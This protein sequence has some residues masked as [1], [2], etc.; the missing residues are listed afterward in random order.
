[1]YRP[2]RTARSRRLLELARSPSCTLANLRD[3]AAELA[4]RKNKLAFQAYL[5]VGRL[6]ES[7]EKEE[8]RQVQ[9]RQQ[10]ERQRVLRRKLEGFFDW[11][12]TDAPASVY[13]FRGDVFF[14]QDGLLRYVGYRVGRQ[15]EPHDIRLQMLDCVFHNDL[16]RVQSPD[17]M[18]E[19]GS[20]KT[21]ARLQKMAESIAA[22]TRNAK[23][24]ASHDYSE[25]IAD[26]ESFGLSLS[27]VL[28]RQVRICVA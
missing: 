16:P 17:Y 23:G 3:I 5:E 8:R 6:L 27:R 1:M 24:N 11:P 14:Y 26:W 19:W 18:A 7:A 25:A 15:G 20:P 9:E 4:E 21:A 28:R 12:S 2:Y 10:A 22:F 13:G